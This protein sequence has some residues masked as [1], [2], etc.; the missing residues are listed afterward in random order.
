MKKNRIKK[1]LVNAKLQASRIDL[2]RVFPPHGHQYVELRYESDP[3]FAHFLLVM[4]DMLMEDFGFTSD[5]VQELHNKLAEALSMR[6]YSK[7]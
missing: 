2:S 7:K 4:D 5:K 6:T 3:V 1:F